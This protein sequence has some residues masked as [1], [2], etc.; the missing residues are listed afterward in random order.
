M[1]KKEL[2]FHEQT[3]HGRSLGFSAIFVPL[4]G[5]G[6]HLDE[7]GNSQVG[8]A[9]TFC[10]K[11]DRFFNKKIAR[12]TLR[13]RPLELVRVKDIPWKLAEARAKCDSKEMRHDNE[14]ISHISRNYNSILRHFV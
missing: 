12:A 6:P 5:T 8:M 1:I 13:D 3:P 4:S 10:N 7:K 14:S 2:F 11:K 9:I